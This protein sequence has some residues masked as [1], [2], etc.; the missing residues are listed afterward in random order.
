MSDTGTG[1]HSYAGRN[2]AIN[3]ILCGMTVLVVSARIFVRAVMLKTV[4]TDDCFIIAATVLGAI[5]FTCYIGGTKNGRGR[6]TVDI[7]PDEMARMLHWEFYHSI[8]NTVGIALVKFSVA[9]FLLRLVPGRRF[10]MFL[11]GAIT[12]LVLFTIASTTVVV[13][14]CTPIRASWDRMGEPD[15][16]CFSKET[17]TALGLTN[18]IVNIL[19]DV[20]F[21]TLP[22][23]V[24]L[25][26]QVNT[27]AKLSLVLILSL[28][29][30][31]CAC[32]IIKTS[33]QVHILDNPNA[34]HQD[35]FFMWGSAEFYTGILAS[36]LPTLRPLFRTFFELHSRMGKSSSAQNGR[37]YVQDDS[38][39]M[40]KLQRKEKY[41]VR[42]SAA[43]L[44]SKQS[45]TSTISPS[46]GRVDSE[47]DVESKGDA[48]SLDIILP[49]QGRGDA[50]MMGITKTVD[51]SVEGTT[52]DV[53]FG[54]SQKGDGA[55]TTFP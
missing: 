4:G 40:D 51:V 49:V 45:R 6:Y 21:A 34:W 11:C 55:Q 41:H 31:A 52:Q 12:F 24:I 26:L 5:V 48:D 46:P 44:P 14:S 53:P 28:G 17:F 16:K 25:K 20:L 42:V 23:P 2:L 39:G 29:Y 13:F 27:Q 9:F 38:F 37:Y 1:R 8:A 32:A 15:A 54:E 7:S 18:S 30:F 3:G 22:I 47:E 43:G 50:A 10:K 33:L 36:S 19:T 35:A